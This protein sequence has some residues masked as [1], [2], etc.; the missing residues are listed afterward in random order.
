MGKYAL[1]IGVKDYGN[2]LQPLP[3]AVNDVAALKEVLENP[4]MGGFDEVQAITNPT[5]G[6]MEREVELWFQRHQK[7]DLVVLFFSGH[8]VKDE[9]RNLYF[10]TCNT[11]KSR[12]ILVRST[13][14]SARF[15]HD[16]ICRCKAKH[17]VVIL[18]CCFSGAF[19]ELVPRDDGDINLQD[20]LGAEGRVV[21]TSTTS[22]DYSFEEKGQNLSIYTRFLVEG[23]ATGAADD[24]GDGD[25]TAEELH[26]YAG[27]KV[28]EASPAMSPK[29][30]IPQGEGYRIKIARSPQDDPRL[31]Y[32]REA[33]KRAGASEFSYA[34]KMLLMDFRQEFDISDKDA[35]AIETEVLKPYREYEQKR[36][37]YQDAMRQCIQRE[38]TLT[39]Y[40]IRDLQ[41][42]REHLQLRPEDVTAIEQTELQGYHLESY[43]VEVKRQQQATEV[44]RQ[45]QLQELAD[46]ERKKREEL[47]RQ[48]K[49]KRQRQAESRTR[50]QSEKQETDDKKQREVEA[51]R[52]QRDTKENYSQVSSLPKSKRA[53]LGG[54]LL[55]VLL[56]S[57]SGISLR[58]SF[59]S[60]AMTSLTLPLSLVNVQQNSLE[61]MLWAVAGDIEVGS[62]WQSGNPTSVRSPQLLNQIPF[63][64]PDA[65][66]S[67]GEAG[68]ANTPVT[69][70]NDLVPT[71]SI[72][73]V[74]ARQTQ[75]DETTWVR[76]LV[77]SIPSGETLDQAPQGT[78]GGRPSAI[79]GS[80]LSRRLSSPGQYGWVS[81]RNLYRSATPVSPTAA[82][83][84]TCTP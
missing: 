39:P 46:L 43:A 19:G 3:A 16:C 44:K 69:I 48:A 62:F 17:Q 72:L 78:D 84:G 79:N 53:L 24:N 83:R 59:R 23:I 71:G 81:E 45:Q 4:K 14:T 52:R 47:E 8:G 34:A 26:R 54:T 55:A 28:K 1:L 65:N 5:R 10:A 29:I 63:A 60:I 77:C 12:D 50:L 36:N 33:E 66:S 41:D 37:K 80:D 40:T 73:K 2:G 35:E 67:S 38:A 56:L 76:L 57:V 58:Y 27:R 9:S 22:V 13:A 64:A 30:F 31:K 11:E 49:A 15:I 7:N 32:R 6:E 70:L 61:V 42:L 20:Q 18:D 68:G 82:Q 51:R 74:V 21:L 75:A 25:I